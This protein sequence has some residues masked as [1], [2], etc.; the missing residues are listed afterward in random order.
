MKA[1]DRDQMAGICICDKQVFARKRARKLT[2]KPGV[3]TP[4]DRGSDPR[5][6][7]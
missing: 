7:H 5:R 2:G 4:P 1:T 6:I 3:F